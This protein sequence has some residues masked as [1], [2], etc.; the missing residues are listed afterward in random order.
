MH[1]FIYNI[2]SVIHFAVRPDFFTKEDMEVMKKCCE[3]DLVDFTTGVSRTS[4]VT[5]LEHNLE[6]IAH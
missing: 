3:G 2:W 4:E 1:A 5:K 6:H